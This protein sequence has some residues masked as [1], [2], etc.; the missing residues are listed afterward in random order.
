MSYVRKER[1]TDD[2][3]FVVIDKYYSLR[4]HGQSIEREHRKTKSN[5]TNEAQ[6]EAN[7]RRSAEKSALKIANNFSEGD[8]YLTFTYDQESLPEAADRKDRADKDLHNT[9]AKIVRR[10]KKAGQEFRYAAVIENSTE[11]AKGRLH[12]HVLVPSLPGLETAASR[13]RFFG[14]LWQKGH[15]RAEEYRGDFTD[16][17]NIANYFTKQKKQLAG[18]RIRFSQNCRDVHEKKKIVKR[19]EC[20]SMDIRVPAGYEIVKELT[21]QLSGAET[22][23]GWPWQHIVLRR[24]GNRAAWMETLHTRPTA[25]MVKTSHFKEE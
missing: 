13:E 17:Q 2:R 6:A 1:Y 15:V 5:V 12:F 16:A 18:A 23:T 8:F 25:L 10:Y 3:Q 7:R 4:F 9:L 22:T 20:Y 19:S 14:A 21:R 11:D 24:T